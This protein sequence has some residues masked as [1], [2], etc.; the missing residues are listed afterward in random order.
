M[1]HL[2]IGSHYDDQT[3]TFLH[4]NITFT[5]IYFFS[6]KEDLVRTIQIFKF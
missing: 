6:D 3:N 2:L 4:L 1:S 5:N